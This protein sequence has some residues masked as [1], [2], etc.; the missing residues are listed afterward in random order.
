MRGGRWIALLIG[1]LLL[2]L[3]AAAQSSLQPGTYTVTQPQPG[4]AARTRSYLLTVTPGYDP[5]V[6]APLLIVLHGQTGSGERVRGYSGFDT[7]ADGALIV[8]PDGV[9]GGWNDGRPGLLNPVDD[10]A[11]LSNV[12]DRVGRVAAID[13]DRVYLVGISAGGMLA[14]RLACVLPGRFA[15]IGIVAGALPVYVRDECAAADPVPTPLIVIHG[16]DDPI[17]PWPG[18]GG[19][20]LSTEAALTFWAERGGCTTTRL[21]T[22]LP[23]ADPVD[24]TRILHS[25]PTGCAAP[26]HLYAVL[27][28]GHTWPGRTIPAIGLGRTAMDID[29]TALIWQFF[30][31]QAAR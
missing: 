30:T 6:P 23:D 13:P 1:V 21:I 19:T 27:F 31:T 16:T 24:G 29:A 4:D 28:G 18:I 22:N 17:L 8:Y 25:Q 26:L 15:A 14:Y 2:T 9:D 11:F 10:A 3:P 7:V 12:I 20:F 5:A